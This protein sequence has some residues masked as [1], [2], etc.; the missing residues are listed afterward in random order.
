MHFVCQ[1]LTM[2]YDNLHWAVEISMC[3]GC[4]PTPISVLDSQAKCLCYLG[5][6]KVCILCHG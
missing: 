4:L 5:D 2:R 1:P 3:K 6:R